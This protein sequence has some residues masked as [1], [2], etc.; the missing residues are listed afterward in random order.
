M[1]LF[2][3]AVCSKMSTDFLIRFTVFVH[4]GHYCKIWLPYPHFA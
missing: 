3:A 1:K 2:R 4:Y